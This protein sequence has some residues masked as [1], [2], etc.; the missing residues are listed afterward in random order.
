MSQPKHKPAE[1][2]FKDSVGNTFWYRGDELHRDGGP[3]TI[4]ANGEGEEW[5]VD[6]NY[7]R[8]DGAA[9]INKTRIEYW[10]NGVH[11]E[12]I[13]TDDQW[14]RFLKVKCLW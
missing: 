1:Y 6:G 14:Q 12:Q 4:W 9:V 5:V 3:A 2:S 8:E 13:Q 7:H 11:Y 10:F